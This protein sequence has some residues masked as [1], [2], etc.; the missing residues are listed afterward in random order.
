M[1]SCNFANSFMCSS[2]F[3]SFEKRNRIVE[4]KINQLDVIR[5]METRELHSIS[6]RISS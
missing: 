6:L 3:V 2:S 4:N 5:N 1:V